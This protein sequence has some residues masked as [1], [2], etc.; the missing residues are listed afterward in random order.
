LVGVIVSVK[1]ILAASAWL[2]A[3]VVAGLSGAA[4]AGAGRLDL[5][6]LEPPSNYTGEV[7]LRFWYGKP[8]PARISRS[9]R[10][11]PGLALDLRQSLDLSAEAYGRFDL[12]TGW[13]LKGLVGGAAFARARSRTKTFRPA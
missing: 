2:A 6:W 13:F 9:F 3:V 12:N 7:G 5:S 4:P 10:L 11:V 8:R 1:S